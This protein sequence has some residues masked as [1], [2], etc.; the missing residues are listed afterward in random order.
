MFLHLASTVEYVKIEGGNMYASAR[1][2]IRENSARTKGN[3]KMFSNVYNG[4][5]YVLLYSFSFVCYWNQYFVVVR[6]FWA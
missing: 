2:V 4:Q 3:L 1:L 5:A 6:Y